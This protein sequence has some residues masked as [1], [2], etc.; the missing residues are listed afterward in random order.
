MVLAKAGM[1]EN[2]YHH[3]NLRNAL[4]KRAVEV[5]R[6]DGIDALSLRGLARD[7]RVSHAAPGRHFK[8]KVEL[9]SAIAREGYIGLAEA[10]DGSGVPEHDAVQRLRAMAKAFVHWAVANPA[11]HNA[12]RHPEVVRH[13]D[14]EL[15]QML[16]GVRQTRVDAIRAAQVA[17]WRA[18]IDPEVLSLQIVATLVGT[19]AL[20]TD[21]FYRDIFE[22][23]DEEAFID[24]TVDS[25]FD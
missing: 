20:L 17:G 22:A 12:M 19:A 8:T 10:S 24:H 2:A 7:L 15:I 23:T 9:L 1:A 25:L 11:H 4:V 5:I 3:G 13:A 21:P 16:R 14:P 18:N 6:D